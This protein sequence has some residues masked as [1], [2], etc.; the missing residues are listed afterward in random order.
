MLFLFLWI[1]WHDMVVS[2]KRGVCCTIKLFYREIK[3]QFSTFLIMLWNT[4]NLIFCFFVLIIE[5]F[6]KHP[7]HNRMVLLNRTIHILE[8]ALTLMIHMHI[9]QYFWF[10]TILC[11]CHLINKMSSSILHGQNT[12]SCPHHGKNMFPLLPR[13]IGCIYFVQDL[14]LGLDELSPRSMKCVF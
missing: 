4:W 14:T 8:V 12:F 10:D 11:A 1:I 2:I 3:T 7:V 9:S 13:V 6:T 5:L